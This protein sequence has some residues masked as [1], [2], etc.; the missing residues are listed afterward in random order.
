MKK[1]PL[2]IALVVTTLMT[3][4]ALADDDCNDQIVDWQSRETLRQML[5]A[6]GW[7]VNRIK[8]DEGC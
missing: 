6:K 7:T 1:S 5:V 2:S 8:V 3:G 4:T